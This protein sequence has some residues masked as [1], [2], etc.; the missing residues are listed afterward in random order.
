M[1]I[2]GR[3]GREEGAEKGKGHED[4]NSDA[5]RLVGIIVVANGLEASMK[6]KIN[7]QCQWEC[8]EERERAE[9]ERGGDGAQRVEMVHRGG[10]ST[11]VHRGG[12]A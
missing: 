8:T 2:G 4:V 11:R 5:P 12:G 7:S 10:D 1:H 9:W 3:R 6:A